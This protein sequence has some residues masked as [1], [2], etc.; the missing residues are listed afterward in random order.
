MHTLAYAVFVISFTIFALELRMD[1]Q[2]HE[3]FAPGAT[4]DG[5][6][7]TFIG[8]GLYYFVVMYYRYLDA[9]NY[10]KPPT[11]LMLGS[12]SASDLF[13][14]LKTSLCPLKKQKWFENNNLQ[15]AAATARTR[16][17]LSRALSKASGLM[18]RRKESSSA[19]PERG[20]LERMILWLLWYV[21]PQ[22]ARRLSIDSTAMLRFRRN[23][24]LYL[25]LFLYFFIVN[26]F[27][28]AGRTDLLN[29]GCLT[30]ITLNTLRAVVDEIKELSQKT[31]F[32]YISSVW[33]I[34][35]LVQVG[36]NVLTVSAYVG[37]GGE[38]MSRS[39]VLF[40]AVGVLL[41]WVRIF[42]FC[43]SLRNVGSFIRMVI[44]IVIDLRYFL[45]VLT[46]VLVG[47]GA[48]F[49]VLFRDDYMSLVAE[50]SISDPT[51]GVTELRE[52]GLKDQ[53]N[54]ILPPFPN[55]I[56]TLLYVYTL[57][58]GDLRVEH[59]VGSKNWGLATV[60]SL[61]LT[62]F[63]MVILFNLLI[64]IMSDTYERVRENEQATFLKTRAETICDMQKLSFR[65]IVYRPWVHALLPRDT[66]SR[67][68][69]DRSLGGWKG[70]LGE[71]KDLITGL[72]Q[73]ISVDIIKLKETLELRHAKIEAGN[74]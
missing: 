11:M 7:P 1:G 38:W 37:I 59:F 30:V 45:I 8:V 16:I 63:L 58:L 52:K 19:E 22:A 42:F 21:S 69:N 66:N 44:E 17:G 48:A 36:L 65:E 34:L 71:I 18:T 60:L 31:F 23:A 53:R 24:L 9:A 35:D 61:L 20:R 39:L 62:F 26:G 43:R 15:Q 54:F 56:E 4:T 41:A 67:Q 49:F 14:S 33:N 51:I 32:S 28:Q 3:P 55:V 27:V 70:K 50:G 40:A 12:L 46:V 72:K 13:Q 2:I 47:F 10:A 29:L 5:R 74:R 73:E 57:M 64:A 6:L 68:E 25:P